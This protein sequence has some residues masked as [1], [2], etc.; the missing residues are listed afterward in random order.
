MDNKRNLLIVFS[1]EDQ[2]DFEITIKLNNLTSFKVYNTTETIIEYL[3][4]SESNYFLSL[5]GNLAI[6]NLYIPSTTNKKGIEEY[7]KFIMRKLK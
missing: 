4:K 7:I 3:D 6:M 2:R 5:D 1:F